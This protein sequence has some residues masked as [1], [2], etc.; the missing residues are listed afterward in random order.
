MLTKYVKISDSTFF[1][2]TF[3]IGCVFQDLNSLVMDA[4]S[5][6]CKVRECFKCQGNTE[7]FCGLCSLELCFQ[8]AQ[9]HTNDL[10]T[11]DHNL[12][13]YR[14]K[15]NF[16]CKQEI[17]M[18]H[19][20]SVYKKYC[21][22]CQVPMCDLCSEHKV[23]K[24]LTCPFT[25][26][27][28]KTLSIREAYKTQHQIHRET[29]HTLR[30][31]TLFTRL[32]L[33]A[34]IKTDFRTCDQKMFNFQSDLLTKAM[35]LRRLLDYAH[36]GNF[37]YI[38]FKQ[39]RKMNRHIARIQSYEHRY[40]QFSANSVQFLSFIKNARLP[41][42]NDSP[43]LSKKYQ[44]SLK[45]IIKNDVME[46]LIKIRFS[47]TGK[48]HIGNKRNKIASVYTYTTQEDA[49]TGKFYYFQMMI[50]MIVRRFIH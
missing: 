1:F 20:E 21:E 27:M 3:F 49:K 5:Q 17:C 34:E 15:F 38:F 12:K 2:F 22:S 16:I 30:S 29:F 7:Y 42:V 44:F 48:R 4:A 6:L 45:P 11:K 9:N 19:H 43:N 25:L 32:I 23:R 31:E 33:M 41:V 28:H 26:S 18:R 35:K 10:K 37:N 46:S 50:M 14:D 8:C 39:V 13:I 36:I 47:E 24:L 40:E